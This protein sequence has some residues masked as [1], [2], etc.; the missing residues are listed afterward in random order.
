MG[1]DVID[2]V[3]DSGTT[4][5]GDDGYVALEDSSEEELDSALAELLSE[6]T[7]SSSDDGQPAE[8]GEPAQEKPPG[9]E[10]PQEEQKPPTAEEQIEKLRADNERFQKMLS[11]NQAWIQQRSAEIGQLRADNKDLAKKLHA[12]IEAKRDEDPLLAGKADR[13]LEEL[14]VELE[15]LDAEEAKLQQIHL[16]TEV[17]KKHVPAEIIDMDAAR[18]S[19]EEDGLPPQ[20]IDEFVKNPLGT[21]SPDA[22]V[23]LIKR[24]NVEKHLRKFVPLFQKVVAENDALKKQLGQKGTQVLKK[25]QQTLKTPAPMRTQAAPTRREPSVTDVANLS[26]AQLEQMLEKSLRDNDG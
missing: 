26:E 18:L 6:E 9:E 4:Q 25:V 16:A 3:E 22:L 13:R 7:N 20:V 10:A 23:H 2:T 17:L 1:Q 5:T 21:V 15:Q 12:V 11:A 8:N 24:A 19:L 14:T